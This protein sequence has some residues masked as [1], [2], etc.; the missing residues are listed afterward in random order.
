MKAAYPDFKIG[1]NRPNDHAEGSAS[2]C[3]CAKN[4]NNPPIFKKV[5]RG[6]FEKL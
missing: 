4:R 2:P 5:S 6:L 1:S 3:R